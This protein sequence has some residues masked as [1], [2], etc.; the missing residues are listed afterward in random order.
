MRLTNSKYI[1]LVC[2]DIANY[3]NRFISDCNFFSNRKN[4]CKARSKEKHPLL[5]AFLSVPLFAR[6]H[7]AALNKNSGGKLSHK[8]TF[9]I[10]ARETDLY[11]DNNLIGENILNF[12]RPKEIHFQL[13]RPER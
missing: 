9:G 5:Q 4:A 6:R 8:F 10:L 2:T 7:R 1:I 12:I 11:Q 3:R 13:C